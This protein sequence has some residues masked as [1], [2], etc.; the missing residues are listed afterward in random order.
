MHV[1]L[2][3]YVGI[4]AGRSGNGPLSVD[5]SAKLQFARSSNNIAP[6]AYDVWC[7]Y[8]FEILSTSPL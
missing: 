6:M 5:Q 4:P 8:A 3:R 2:P 1:I 7:A